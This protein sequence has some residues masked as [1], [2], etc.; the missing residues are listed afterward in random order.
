MCVYQHM[1]I[2]VKLNNVFDGN[3]K[4]GGFGVV[5]FYLSCFVNSKTI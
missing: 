4:A 1:L 3:P 2:S 5:D